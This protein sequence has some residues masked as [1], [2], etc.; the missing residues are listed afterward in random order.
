MRSSFLE[1]DNNLSK[2]IN[3]K[4]VKKVEHIDKDACIQITFSDESYV[5]VEGVPDKE[6]KAVPLFHY[7]D[8]SG[9]PIVYMV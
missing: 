2:I 6:F 4:I 5:V 8:V 9:E 7:Y 1:S 3:G